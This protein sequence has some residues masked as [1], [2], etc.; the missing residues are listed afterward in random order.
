MIPI[1]LGLAHLL[2]A[3]IGLGVRLRNGIR[4]V[5]CLVV[6]LLDVGGHRHLRD[7]GLDPRGRL[8]LVGGLGLVLGDVLGVALV[9]APVLVVVVVVAA[10]HG[11]GEG[12]GVVLVWEAG[13]GRGGLPDGEEGDDEAGELHDGG[14][15]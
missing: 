11:H 8:G 4:L 10:G 13:A 2:V 1:P 3:H 12:A 14:L 9:L 5:L 6:R 7:H 15:G